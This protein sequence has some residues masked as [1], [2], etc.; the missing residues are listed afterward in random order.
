MTLLVLDTYRKIS[1]FL[2]TMWPHYLK[3]G[4]DMLGIERTNS[5]TD[6][7]VNIPRLAVGED[8]F[9]RWCEH[10]SRTL[11]IQ[12]WL[13]ILDRS[14]Q[15]PLNDK[16]SDFCFSEWNVLFA[17]PIPEFNPPAMMTLAGGPQPPFKANQLFHTPWWIQR[18]L[19]PEIVGMGKKMML[20]GEYEQGAPDFFFGLIFDRM[21]IPWHKFPCW[22]C[23]ALV[24]DLLINQARKA[25]LDGVVAIH[26]VKNEQQL[27]ALLA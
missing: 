20:N 11:L 4:V 18:E 9:M 13:D 17:K 19:I 22:P 10:H 2:K 27:A 8:N 12:R 3:A 6:W 21:N 7:P 23:N 16:Y 5:P 14:L 15:S 1:P 24:G 26:G 25:L